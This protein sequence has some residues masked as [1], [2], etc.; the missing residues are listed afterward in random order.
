LRRITV[1]L[2][3]PTRDGETELHLLTNVPA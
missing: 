3:Q 1:L 2:D